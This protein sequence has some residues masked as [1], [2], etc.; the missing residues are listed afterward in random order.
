MLKDDVNRIEEYPEQIE[1]KEVVCRFCGQFRKAKVIKDWGVQN[2]DE[3]GVELCDCQEAK[4]YTTRKYRK[5]RALLKARKMFGEESEQPVKEHILQM[6]YEGI[7]LADKEE[8][9]KITIEIEKGLK[10]SIQNTAKGAIK[11]ERSKIEK[12]TFEE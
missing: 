8:I 7:E 10:A 3:I 1:E 12:K 5:E 4:E 9:K 11:V 6:I 2:L